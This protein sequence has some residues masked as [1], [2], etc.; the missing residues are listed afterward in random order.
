MSST[1]INFGI[2]VGMNYHLE[3]AASLLS[4]A[5]GQG[6]SLGFVQHHARP[7]ICHTVTLSFQVCLL[8]IYFRPCINLLV[9]FSG[10]VASLQ[11]G[12]N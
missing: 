2:N 1:Y 9:V 4:G 12:R 10:T 3:F 8:P 11:K 7:K 6:L 5:T